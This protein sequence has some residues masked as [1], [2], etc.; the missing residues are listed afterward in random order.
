M[1]PGYFLLGAGKTVSSV[2]QPKLSTVPSIYSSRPTAVPLL[3]HDCLM[4]CFYPSSCGM[5]PGA[6]W[7]ENTVLLLAK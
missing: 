5:P 1:E 2:K 7:G 3:L 6:A 4:S